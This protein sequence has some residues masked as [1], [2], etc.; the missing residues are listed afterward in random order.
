M[1]SFGDEPAAGRRAREREESPTKHHYTIVGETATLR[2]ADMAATDL[3]TGVSGQLCG[4]G[5]L[6][7]GQCLCGASAGVIRMLTGSRPTSSNQLDPLTWPRAERTTSA[8]KSRSGSKP[9][10]GDADG[11]GREEGCV[12]PGTQ[13]DR[14][15]GDCR[16]GHPDGPQG[17]QVSVQPPYLD[18]SR[19]PLQ[20]PDLAEEQ[21]GALRPLRRNSVVTTFFP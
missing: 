19:R 14:V 12:R 6:M 9:G 10:W 18:R 1:S 17:R 8:P 21:R 3:R 15:A 20:W 11:H 7:M 13:G 2:V 5:L 4:S 16:S